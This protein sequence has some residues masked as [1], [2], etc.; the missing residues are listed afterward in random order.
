MTEQQISELTV[1]EIIELIRRLTEE[2]ELRF[3]EMC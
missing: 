1:T 2:L 3:M